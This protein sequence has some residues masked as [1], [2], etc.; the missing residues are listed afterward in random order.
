MIPLEQS[1]AI[2]AWLAEGVDRAADRLVDE[3]AVETE[4]TVLETRCGRLSELAA[5]GFLSEGE[6][7][8]GVMRAYRGPLEG[9]AL[10]AMDPEEALAWSL[11]DGD[12]HSPVETYIALGG[13]VLQAVAE[14]AAESLGVEAQLST[15]RLEE[16]TAA[17]CLLATH[18]P[19]E[20]CAAASSSGR[21]RP[22][23]SPNARIE[24]QSRRDAS[25]ILELNLHKRKK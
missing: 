18:A 24:A 6:R 22:A 8:A 21:A 11:A 14:V 20:V 10:L 13:R 23:P 1:L 19:P 7:I 16:S 3:H 25:S 15:A 9:A 5:E 17:G 12:G 4:I 2:Q